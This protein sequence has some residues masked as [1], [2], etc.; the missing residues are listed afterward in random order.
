ME[1]LTGNIL[2]VPVAHRRVTF[3]DEVRREAYRWRP[4][5][6]AVELPATLS[7]WVVR[8]V[9]R[10]PRLSAVCWQEPGTQGELCWLPVD[11]CDGLIEAVRLACAHAIPLEF[12]DL[13]LPG[14]QEPHMPVPDDLIIDK[15][16]LDPYVE[17][18]APYLGSREND[19]R[20]LARECA[21]A[22]HLQELSK[23]HER[24]L[25][26][27][28]MAHWLRVRELVA[29]TRIADPRQLAPDALD[30]REGVTLADLTADSLTE[31]LGE[32]PYLAW[33]YEKT[34]E[35]LAL[36][37]D[38]PF[39]KIAAVREILKLAEA[40]YHKNTKET[41]N[42]TQWKGL[43]Q[44]LRNLSVARGRLRPDMYELVVGARG[45]VDGDFGYEVLE[46]ARSY[47]PQEEPPPDS[48]PRVRLAR[49]RGGFLGRPERYRLRARWE[50]PPSEMVRLRLRRRPDK[51][52]RQLWREQ[53]KRSF[54][55]GICSWPPEDE[56]Q[57]RFMDYLR[58]RALQVVTEDRRQV[59][60]FTT[61]LL[62]GL[63]LRETLRNWHTGKLYV[64]STP[65]PAG[66]V[67]AVVLLMDDEPIEAVGYPWRTTLFAENQNESD[68]TFF[69][70]P[71]GNQM[72]GPRIC[73]TEFGGLLSV[74]PAWGIPNIWS[75]EPGGRIKT[76][77]EALT[78]AAVLFSPGRY[79]AYVAATP[80]SPLMRELAQR[81][82]RHLI[83]M[84]LHMF[85]PAHLKKIRRFHILDGHDVRKWARDY[86]D[87]I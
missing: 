13:D 76:C 47:P 8:G 83:Y 25:C 74:Y 31:A 24:V 18:L 45:M 40:D 2:F 81:H 39:D 35:E 9:M 52:L 37:G 7:D 3:A 86:I 1:R 53:W 36:T 87:E 85:S 21:M 63:D 4:D 82:G 56:L 84:P 20:A 5:V 55:Q 69:A 51:R 57:E 68:I 38:E 29:Q 22:R 15:T 16:G 80:P 78:L 12:I 50:Q 71:L 61:S 48:L 33:L 79:I 19:T 75:F 64:Q 34:R 54:G 62:D 77:G 66:Q 44:Y 43:M 28:G 67:G 73:R 42:I 32:I 70:T 59:Q 23:T 60:E 10:L 27:L 26:V 11:P 17:N 14:H 46:Q 72:V 41:I 49:D 65:P 6:I 58:K 30:R